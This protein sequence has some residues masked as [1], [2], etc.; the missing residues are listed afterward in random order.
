MGKDI[1]ER[2]AQSEFR[3]RFKLSE[4]DIAYIKAKGLENIKKHA[5]DFIKK[6]IAPASIKNDGKQTPMKNHPV[7][8]AQHATATCCRGCIYKWHGF[9]QGKELS[10]DEQAY[11]VNIIMEWINRQLKQKQQAGIAKI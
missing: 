8:V 11:I 5:E 3:R 9:T 2:L 7:F 6:R 4:K 10:N 1:F